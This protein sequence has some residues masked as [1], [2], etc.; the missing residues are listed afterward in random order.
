MASYLRLS[1]VAVCFIAGV[2][3]VN[4]PGGPKEQVRETPTVSE[5]PI[6]LLFSDRGRI[7]V[8]GRPMAGLGFDG[9]ICSG[10]TQ[11]QVDRRSIPAEEYA[12]SLGPLERKGL[13]LAP[14]GALSIAIV[15]SAEDLYFSPIIPWIVTAVIGGAIVAG[16]IV[17]AHCAVRRRRPIR[18]SLPGSV[19]HGAGD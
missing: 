14:L 8:A 11:R 7:A 10:Q 3:L 2:I 16:V 12:E 15:V 9:F 17:Q 5:R 4:L 18:R 6:Y 1:P 13:V 19:I